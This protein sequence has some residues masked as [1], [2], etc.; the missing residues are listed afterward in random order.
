MIDDK[1]PNTK[2]PLPHIDN[3]LEEDVSRL[4]AALTMIDEGLTAESDA[5]FALAARMEEGIAAAQATA[6]AA[7]TAAA[8]WTDSKPD[9]V[10]RVAA[11]EDAE[12]CLPLSGGTISGDVSV[13]GSLTAG[14]I[15]N[16]VWNDYAEFFPRAPE[17][18]GYAATAPGDIIAF[19]AEASAREGRDVYRAA[20]EGDICLAGVHSDS[21]GHL[22][23]GEK[24]PEG[25]DFFAWNIGRCIPVGLAGRVWC[26]VTN[27]GEL[28]ASALGRRVT[29]SAEPGAGRLWRDGDDPRAVAGFIV[30]LPDAGHP[31]RVLLKLRPV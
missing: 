29:P 1:T 21:F 31:G 3:F 20:R 13:T 16:A 11:L 9:M 28:D 12:A 4:R 14:S 8:D 5:R 24:A 10:A 2:L 25:K 30:R 27:A 19:D 17:G 26:R 7:T 22:V 23:G 18:E 15:Y 6:D